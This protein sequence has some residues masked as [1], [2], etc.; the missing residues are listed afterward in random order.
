M[1][2]DSSLGKRKLEGGEDENATKKAKGEVTGTGDFCYLTLRVKLEGS[3]AERVLTVGTHESFACLAEGII[4]AF[5]YDI[6]RIYSFHLDGEPFSSNGPTYYSPIAEKLPSSDQVLLAE[7]PWTTDQQLLLLYDYAECHNFTITVS[8]VQTLLFLA[9]LPS[10]PSQMTMKDEEAVIE[11]DHTQSKGQPP[12]Q[13]GPETSDEEFDVSEEEGADSDE[14]EASD[15]D[16]DD[17]TEY[18]PRKK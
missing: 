18:K 9:T 11:V 12:S 8:Q 17:A 2:E 5:S 13:G 7:I 6:L 3:D 4:Q 14:F 1:S 15:E 16:E 10:H